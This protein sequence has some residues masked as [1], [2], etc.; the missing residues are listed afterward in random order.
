MSKRLLQGV[1]FLPVLLLGGCSLVLL[2]PAGYVARQQ[3]DVMVTTTIIIASIIIPVLIAVGVVAWRYRASNTQARYEPEWDHSPQI[4]LLVWAWP[5]LVIIAVGAVSWIGT[6]RLDPY[7]PLTHVTRDKPV[8]AGV[9]PLEIEVVSL[10]WKWLFLYP[11]YGV[12]TVNELAAP[13]DRP[14]AFKLTAAQFMNSFFIPTLAGQIYTMPGMQTQLNAVINLP[15]RYQGFSANYSGA[16][17]TDMR[18][19]FQ[20]LEQPAFEQWIRKVQASTAQLDRAA[21]EGLKRPS[22]GEPVH[23][24]ARFM[25]DLYTRILHGCADPGQKCPVPEQKPMAH[26]AQR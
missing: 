10:P 15:G 22:R 3:S 19:L 20:G 23:Y 8:P 17:F 5:M 24:Y 16:G 13:I 25:P 14:I 26:I 7:R 1:S 18:F 11:Q 21:Y 2:H 12:A 9:K 4:E 6:H